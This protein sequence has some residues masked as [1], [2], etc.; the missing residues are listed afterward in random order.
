MK[1]RLLGFGAVEV[2]GR[3]Y[4]HTPLSSGEHLPWGGRELIIGTGV[5]G[6][7]SGS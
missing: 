6:L 5:H 7:L 3:R 1:A 2:D 4:G